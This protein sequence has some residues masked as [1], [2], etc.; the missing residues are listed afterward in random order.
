MWEERAEAGFP[1]A[2]GT[3]GGG[4]VVKKK[5]LMCPESLLSSHSSS[6]DLCAELQSWDQAEEKEGLTLGEKFKG[7]TKN[8]V[9]KTNTIL[10]QYFYFI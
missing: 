5:L 3:A 8:S 4:H 9:T 6:S 2:S 10:R 7:V 1:H